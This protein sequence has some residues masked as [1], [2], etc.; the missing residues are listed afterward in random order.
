MKRKKP[1]T[2]KNIRAAALDLLR[3]PKFL[4][5]VKEHI[6]AAGVVGEGRNRLVLYLACLTCVLDKK[7]SVLVKGATSTGKNNL[8]RTVLSM[9]PPEMVLTRSSF[10][11]TALAY[12]AEQLAGKI[13]YLVEHRGGKDAQFFTRLLQSEGALHHEATTVSGSNRGTQVTGRSGA[14]VFVST[15]TDERVYEDDE[16]RFLS[17]RADESEEL[18][19]MV[20]QAQF[21]K[22]NAA[23]IKDLSIW[24][25]AFRI[26]TEGVPKFSYPAWFEYLGEEI[27]AGDSRAR[28]DAPRFL[29][30][31]EAVTLCRSF[32]DGRK[33]S[34]EVEIDFVDYCVAYSIL[35]EAF[36]STYAGAHPMAMK[37]AEAV[38]LLCAQSKKDIT[39]KEVAAYLDWTDAVAHTYL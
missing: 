7:V 35:N 10:S 27:P 33:K 26:L 13:L 32:A 20:L 31:L 22:N 34:Q 15:T 16:T 18:T 4:F 25:E 36:A 14:P 30:L 38:R 12:G 5:A 9:L 29:G 1:Q 17:I 2:N 24:Q 11:K 6:E 23:Q 19:R 39:T 37:F 21:S 3:D 28:R 8:A